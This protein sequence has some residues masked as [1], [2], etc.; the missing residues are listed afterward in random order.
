MKLK[1][2]IPYKVVNFLIIWATI[3]LSRRTV[4]HAGGQGGNKES[5]CLSHLLSVGFQRNRG[6]MAKDKPRALLLD[7]DDTFD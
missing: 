4:P 7:H 6:E 1:I 5:W 3:S 2:R